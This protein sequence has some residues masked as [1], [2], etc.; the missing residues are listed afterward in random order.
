MNDVN[1]TRAL[2]SSF[3]GA[4]ET[5]SRLAEIRDRVEALDDQ[6]DIDMSLLEDL[7]RLA[8]A[9]AVASAALRGLLNAIQTRRAAGAS[10]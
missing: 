10:A 6:T 3:R 2:K 8:S 5:G 9:Q 1:E 7:S 4:L